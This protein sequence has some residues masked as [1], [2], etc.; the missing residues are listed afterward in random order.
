MA[1]HHPE[2][3]RARSSRSLNEWHRDHRQGAASHDPGTRWKDRHGDRQRNIAKARPET[4]RNHKGHEDSRQGHED[5]HNSLAEI[6][7]PPAKVTRTDPE[8]RTGKSAHEDRH[9]P[10]QERC[11]RSVN[12]PAK[13]V[14]AKVVRPQQVL[15]IRRLE[16]RLGRLVLAVRRERLGKRRKQEKDREDDYSEGRRWPAQQTPQGAEAPPSGH[17][18][19]CSRVEVSQSSARA[20]ATRILGSTRPYTMSVTTFTSTINVPY[21]RT[22]PWTSG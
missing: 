14:A 3:S 21:R 22:I 1:E 7:N 5:V 11:P 12:H 15:E 18:F 8:Q 9:H 10:Y 13:H 4:G 2:M 6:V 19:A 17:E 20:H 16:V